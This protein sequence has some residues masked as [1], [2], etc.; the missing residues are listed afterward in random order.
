VGDEQ[1]PKAELVGKTDEGTDR[2]KKKHHR[3]TCDDIGIHHG[4]IGNGSQRGA[5]NPILHF[6]DADRGG[7]SDDSG[8][9][10]GTDGKDQRILKRVKYLRTAE[11]LAIPIEGEAVEGT[12]VACCVE[13][14]QHQ[15]QDGDIEDHEN[16]RNINFGYIFHCLPSSP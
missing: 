12:G 5:E 11:K 14:K 1:C 8:D 4:D 3:D 9:T 7:C 2:D 13:G 10:G 6:N 16:E 15:Y